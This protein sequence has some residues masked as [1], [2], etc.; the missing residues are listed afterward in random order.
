MVW[1][2]RIKLLVEVKGKAREEIKLESAIPLDLELLG[3]WKESWFSHKEYKQWK[4]TWP[5][6]F[7][8]EYK[9]GKIHKSAIVAELGNKPLGGSIIAFRSFSLDNAGGRKKAPMVLFGRVKQKVKFD[10]FS[11]QME[12]DKDQE[13][14][15]KK[16]LKNDAWTPLAIWHHKKLEPSDMSQIVNDVIEYAKSVFKQDSNS[17]TYIETE[18]FKG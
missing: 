9:E 16:L 14:F 10:F 11:S 13:K 2:M 18:V 4:K 3:K 7:L 12:L 6:E 17:S 8:G 15:I 1:S 5:K